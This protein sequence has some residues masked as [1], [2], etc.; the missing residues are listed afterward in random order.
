MRSRLVRT[1]LVLA[2]LAFP[3]IQPVVAQDPPDLC[4]QAATVNAGPVTIDGETPTTG[5]CAIAM[6]SSLPAWAW[7]DITLVPVC[8]PVEGAGTSA[9]KDGAYFRGITRDASG[10]IVS[11][12][13]ITN[14]S[15]CT[16]SGY[17][18]HKQLVM[19]GF[20]R[21]IV[22]VVERRRWPFGG[23]HVVS[24]DTDRATAAAQQAQAGQ[25][26][27]MALVTA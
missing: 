17:V 19:Q 3:A 10:A 2:L 24:T 16:P 5:Q 23:S 25:Q 22:L 21:T 15:G 14:W 13:N 26:M 8:Q 6:G 18:V 12:S 7:L 27:V 1:A 20:D 11:Q 4:G 9:I